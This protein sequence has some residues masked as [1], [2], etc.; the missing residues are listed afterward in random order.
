MINLDELKE[1][2]PTLRGYEFEQAENACRR[3]GDLTPDIAFSKNFCIRLAAK[4]M[5]MKI[6]ELQKLNICEYNL[7]AATVSNFLF[8]N[9]AQEAP[10]GSTEE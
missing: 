3:S 4:A 10:A 7:V 9:L 5:R 2:L 8:G 1:K 6:E